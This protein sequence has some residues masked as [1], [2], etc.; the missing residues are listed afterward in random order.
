MCRT[1]PVAKIAHGHCSATSFLGNSFR[2]KSVS[3]DFKNITVIPQ[4]IAPFVQ[5]DF[6]II[7]GFVINDWDFLRKS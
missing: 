4:F 7:K 2:R 1:V 3:A 6:G 5:L